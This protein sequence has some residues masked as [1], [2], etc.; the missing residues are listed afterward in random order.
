LA[1]SIA[2]CNVVLL[3][4]TPSGLDIEATHHALKIVEAVRVRRRDPLQVAIVPNRVDM[5]TLEGR[6]LADELRQMGE[7]VGPAIGNRS[8]FV[9]AFSS[10]MAVCDHAPGSDADREIR[11]L[12]LTVQRMLGDTRKPAAANPRARDT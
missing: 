1:A 5:R 12:W 7:T 11:A 8:A 2:V 10:G 9:R 3:P 4:C 6:Q